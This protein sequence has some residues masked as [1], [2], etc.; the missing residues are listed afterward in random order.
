MY[1]YIRSMSEAQSK[2][3]DKLSSVANQIDMHIIKILLYPESPYVDH[4][5]HEV[6]SFLNIVGKLKGSNKY[7]KSAFIKKSLSIYNDMIDALIQL[8][9]DSESELTPADVPLSCIKHCLED[10][11]NW[12][13]SELSS[14]GFVKQSDVKSK[15]T[16][17][18]FN[19]NRQY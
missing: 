19:N 6:W 13:S 17:I 5:M 7:P 18:C 10:Y 4:W 16:E 8:V 1:I 11:Q 2:I 3:Y 14:H 9:W 15:L 12:I